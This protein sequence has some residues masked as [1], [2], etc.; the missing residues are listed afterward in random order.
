MAKK[1]KRCATKSAGRSTAAKRVKMSAKQKKRIAAVIAGILA[2]GIIFY[3]GGV[4]GSGSWAICDWGKKA[5]TAPSTDTEE[6]GAGDNTDTEEPGADDN[7]EPG[8]GDNTDIEPGDNE[9]PVSSLINAGSYVTM[10]I[11]KD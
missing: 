3:F 11:Y 8:D 6:P 9:L 10:G 7:T 1:I 2:T 5:V 4:V